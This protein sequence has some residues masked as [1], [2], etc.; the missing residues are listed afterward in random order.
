MD[1]W[2][3]ETECVHIAST[4]GAFISE[5]ECSHIFHNE[6]KMFNVMRQM[7]KYFKMNFNEQCVYR[8]THSVNE[9]YLKVHLFQDIYHLMKHIM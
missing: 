2:M 4:K 1:G 5:Q 9:Y 8:Q 7:I 3:M 6:T